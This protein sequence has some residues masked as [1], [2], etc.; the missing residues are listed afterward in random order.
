MIFRFDYR[1]APHRHIV[2][3]SRYNHYVKAL[4]Q[5]GDHYFYKFLT[6]VFNDISL[7]SRDDSI[8]FSKFGEADLRIY[9][10]L[11]HDVDQAE[12]FQS[13][14]TGIKELYSKR[15]Y[16]LKKY[17]YILMLHLNESKLNEYSSGFFLKGK[18]LGNWFDI[19]E[20]DSEEESAGRYSY[21]SV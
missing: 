17:N 7:Y 6:D 20:E 1:E 16:Y 13:I 4:Q 8:S 12:A 5:L 11:K 3:S 19:E 14:Y 10:N 2:V 9:W 18:V 15:S 21:A